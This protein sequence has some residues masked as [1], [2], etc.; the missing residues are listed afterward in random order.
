MGELIAA[1]FAADLASPGIASADNWVAEDAGE[2]VPESRGMSTIDTGGWK[3]LD[4]TD[5]PSD[6]KSKAWGA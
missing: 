4:S 6:P 2:F 5:L 3:G 1:L